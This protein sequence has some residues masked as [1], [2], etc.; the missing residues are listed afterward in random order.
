LNVYLYIEK[1][2]S[3]STTKYSE[4]N[5]TINLDFPFFEKK[6]NLRKKR[7]HLKFN[8]IMITSNT[9]K[10]IIYSF[11]FLGLMACGGESSSTKKSTAK[12]ASTTTPTPNVCVDVQVTNFLEVISMQYSTNFDSQV[13]EL[14]EVKNPQLKDLSAKLDGT[15]FAQAKGENNTVRLSWFAQDL[16][17]VS[18]YDGST[19]YQICFKAKGKSGTKTEI[20][21]AEKPMAAC[22]VW[23]G[24]DY[25]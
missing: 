6:C 3:H 8:Q 18:L 7:N 10:L 19:I 20:D 17:G 4:K 9:L 21:F 1:K 5:I 13:L 24:N 12:V 14:V 15:N 11:F 25:Y 22:G 16:K 23:R 2:L